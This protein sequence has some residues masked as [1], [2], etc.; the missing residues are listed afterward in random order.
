MIYSTNELIRN[1]FWKE[2]NEEQLYFDYGK[3]KPNVYLLNPAGSRLIF[4]R[5][6]KIHTYLFK[7]SYPSFLYKLP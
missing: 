3:G 4:S 1:E 5:N 2:N 7:N 6:A